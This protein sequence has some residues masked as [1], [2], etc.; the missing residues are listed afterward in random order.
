MN[1]DFTRWARAARLR[2][3]VVAVAALPMLASSALAQN[4]SVTDLG[5]LG[6]AS[7]MGFGLNNFGRVVG[8][9]NTEDYVLHGFVWDG[10]LTDLAPLPDEQECHA[11]DVNDD[12]QTVAMSFNLGALT[13]HGLIWHNGETT[14]LGAIAPHGVNAAG[15]VAGYLSRM[16]GDLWVDRAARW[17]H[18]VMTE[19]DS[20]GG[21]FC[22][23]AAI[24]DSGRVVGW[25]YTGG[26]QIIRATL[27]Q[28]DVPRDLGTLGGTNSQAYDVNENGMIVG[29]SDAANGEPHAVRYLVDRNGFVLERRDLGTLEDGYSYAYGVN[30]AGDVVGTA[31]GIAVMWRD[32]QIADLN[33]VLPPQ[34]GW[35]LDVAWGINDDGAIVGTG[36]YDGFK[37]AFL[38]RPIGDINCD[39]ISKLKAKCKRGQGALTAKVKSGLEEGTSLTLLLDGGNARVLEV[40]RKGKVKVTWTN[41]PDG[42]HEVCIEECPQLCETAKCKP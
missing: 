20:L 36:M 12:G 8:T 28:D 17:D 5:S 9:S 31:D 24:A 23:A 1:C 7:S 32:G 39:A 34:S 21:D 6:G 33:S 14:D 29:Y 40:S 13:T 38:L 42:Q 3:L 25:S 19:L 27:W 2:R 10:G 26:D 15:V 30:S 37:R 18:G 4:Y 16:E 22:Y 35:R 41:V 11:F